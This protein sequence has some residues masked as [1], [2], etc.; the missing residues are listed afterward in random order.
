MD[1]RLAVEGHLTSMDPNG[2]LSFSLRRF[3]QNNGKTPLR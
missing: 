3:G 1:L 2:Q